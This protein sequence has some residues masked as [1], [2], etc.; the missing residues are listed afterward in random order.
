MAVILHYLAEIGL[1]SGA[2]YV[3]VVKLDRCWLP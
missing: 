2:D 3:K 1:R